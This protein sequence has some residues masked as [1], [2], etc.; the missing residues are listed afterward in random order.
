MKS[1]TTHKIAFPSFVFSLLLSVAFVGCSSMQPNSVVN[2]P[3]ATTPTTIIRENL[4]S[5]GFVPMMPG[6]NQ[7]TI[8]FESLPPGQI[9]TIQ[10]QGQTYFVYPEQS[11]HQVLIGQNN[12][13]V[14]YTTLINQKPLPPIANVGNS[15]QRLWSNNI[16]HKT[17][18]SSVVNVNNQNSEQK[19]VNNSLVQ[20]ELPRLKQTG[21]MIEH[22]WNHQIMPHRHHSSPA[23]TASPVVDNNTSVTNSGTKPS[24]HKK[25][26]NLRKIG[27]QLKQDW[28]KNK[29]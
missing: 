21:N 1:F 7:T 25:N 11:T 5:S 29:V 3:V 15:I 14:K 28:D 10:S 19:I 26:I 8:A 12:N 2:V 23:A 20:Q 18:Q 22:Y 24:S 13:F 4:L 16:I 17:Q 6:I 27:D 9:S